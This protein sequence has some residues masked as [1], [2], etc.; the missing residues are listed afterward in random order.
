MSWKSRWALATAFCLAITTGAARAQIA[1]PY[2]PGYGGYGWGG[3]SGVGTA[4]GQIARGLGAFNRGEGVYNRKTAIAEAINTNTVMRWNNYLYRSQQA[5]NRRAHMRREREQD[6]RIEA[7]DSIQ[8]R[9]RK[10]PTVEDIENGD[11]LNE[12]LDQVTDPGVHSSAL[13]EATAPVAGKAIREIP[14]VNAA[15]AVTIGL[16]R[17]TA[18]NGWPAALRGP[19]FAQERQAYRKAIE[20]VL[21]EAVD[22]EE[23]VSRQSLQNLKGALSQLRTKLEGLPRTDPVE[24]SRAEDYLKTLAGM[25]RLLDRPRIEKILAELETVEQ[26]T[27][28]SLLGFMHTYNLRFGR[29]STPRQR[30]VYQELY[31]TLASFRDKLMKEGGTRADRPTADDGQDEPKP[32]DFFRGMHLD[33]LS[34]EAK[35]DASAK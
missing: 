8:E 1:S 27:L 20:A 21:A 24:S 7:R 22:K 2:Y 9:L 23:Q 13:R 16:H 12:V 30:T 14:F 15:Q 18:E 33:D 34:G 3:W 6:R 19:A 10:N 32:T 29:A 5:A 11:A 17:L 35:E 4:Q 25:S 28:G 31:P 26:A